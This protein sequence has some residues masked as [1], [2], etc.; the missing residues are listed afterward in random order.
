MTD[1]D[2][3]TNLGPAGP[4]NASRADGTR[5]PTRPVAVRLRPDEQAMLAELRRGDEPEG[6]V[7][8]RCLRDVWGSK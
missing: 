1:R 7:L 5:G 4:A 2:R 3:I 8:R 6:E